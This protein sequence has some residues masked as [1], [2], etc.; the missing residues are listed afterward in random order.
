MLGYGWAIQPS[1]G[2][3]FDQYGELAA[4]LAEVEPIK[5]MFIN[6]TGSCVCLPG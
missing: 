6:L 3:L 4:T 2:L 5:A 1:T